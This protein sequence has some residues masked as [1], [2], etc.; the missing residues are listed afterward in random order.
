MCPW[1]HELEEDDYGFYHL[2]VLLTSIIQKLVHRCKRR[3]LVGCPS[4]RG[5][6]LS[7][8]L[9]ERNLFHL[10]VPLRQWHSPIRAA[11]PPELILKDSIFVLI[12]IGLHF[13]FENS[14]INENGKKVIKNVNG[15]QKINQELRERQTRAASSFTPS[16]DT[17]LTQRAT[18]SGRKATLSPLEIAFI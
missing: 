3:S 10:L 11:V 9:Q 2:N 12:I 13:Y 8:S 18:R 1:E 16:T 7:E 17:I 6:V 4:Q 14:V 5:P 15:R